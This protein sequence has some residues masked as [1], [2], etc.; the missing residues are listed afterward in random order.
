MTRRRHTGD[1]T[2]ADFDIVKDTI[3][4]LAWVAPSLTIRPAVRE[5]E[6]NFAIYLAND[7]ENSP[8][9]N[10]WPYYRM[11]RDTLCAQYGGG[12]LYCPR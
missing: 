10:V 6:A 5:E 11:W 1:V 7:P 8:D 3:E 4:V 9:A 2:A 12:A